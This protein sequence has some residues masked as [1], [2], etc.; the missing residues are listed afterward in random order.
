[1]NIKHQNQFIFKDIKVKDASY[2]FT[3]I[4]EDEQLARKKLKNHLIEVIKQ[5]E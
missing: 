2:T 4:A 1:M 5:I 3:V